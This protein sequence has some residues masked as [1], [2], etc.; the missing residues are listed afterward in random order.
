MLNI[1]IRHLTNEDCNDFTN[2]FKVHDCKNIILSFI[3]RINLV[4]D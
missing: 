4:R 2:S 1:D 3:N